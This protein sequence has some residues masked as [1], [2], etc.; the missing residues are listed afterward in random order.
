MPRQKSLVTV[1][2][3]WVQEEDALDHRMD[4]LGACGAIKSLMRATS[5][6]SVFGVIS[7]RSNS[8]T[9][10]NASRRNESLSSTR[11]SG[12]ERLTR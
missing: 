9:V 12:L 6:G 4:G 1:I 2:R 8:A 5:R 11:A 3:D 10:R 7:P